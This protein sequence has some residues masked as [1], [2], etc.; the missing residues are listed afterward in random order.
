MFLLLLFSRIIYEVRTY[1]FLPYP[2]QG[3]VYQVLIIW[4]YIVIS[5]R[6][7][8][9]LLDTTFDCILIFEIGL[10]FQDATFVS[11][12][13]WRWCLRQLWLTFLWVKNGFE[14]LLF[15]PPVPVLDH[16]TRFYRHADSHYFSFVLRILF[17]LLKKS[18]PP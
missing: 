15:L 8:K 2:T 1:Y 9:D 14:F 4:P 10:F 17:I 18:N 7:L 6:C 3:G 13:F 12:C 5:V 16:N 11:L